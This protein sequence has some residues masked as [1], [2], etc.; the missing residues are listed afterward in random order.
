ME[1]AG[2]APHR[3]RC[4]VSRNFPEIPAQKKSGRKKWIGPGFHCAK[5]TRI[6]AILAL[7]APFPVEEQGGRI[8][9][10]SLPVRALRLACFHWHCHCWNAIERTIRSFLWQKFSALI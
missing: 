1:P 5:L 6:S 7:L 8:I 3:R 10:N 9:P 2:F 4:R